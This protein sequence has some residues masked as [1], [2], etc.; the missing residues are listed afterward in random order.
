M[1]LRFMIF[2]L[3]KF[4]G[5]FVCLFPKKIFGFASLFVEEEHEVHVLG[6][7]EMFLQ[8]TKRKVK[9]KLD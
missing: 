3:A 9:K 8:K 5:F 1:A 2:V 6:R 7:E 4:F